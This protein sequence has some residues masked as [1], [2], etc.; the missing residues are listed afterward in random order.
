[1]YYRGQV[2]F[3][4]SGRSQKK[5]NKFTTYTTIFR[6]FDNKCPFLQWCKVVQDMPQGT[7]REVLFLKKMPPTSKQEQK[8]FKFVPIFK[9]RFLRLFGEIDGHFEKCILGSRWKCKNT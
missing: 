9:M 4:T 6:F 5:M 2:L 8:I 7:S 3:L 1:M